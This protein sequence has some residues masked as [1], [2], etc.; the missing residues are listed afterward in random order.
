MIF[1]TPKDR[2]L[3]LSGIILFTFLYFHQVLLR[4]VLLIGLLEHSRHS[5]GYE[6]KYS[7]RKNSDPD[8]F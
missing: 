2:R 1:S 3:K 6:R 7:K 8:V 5:A 4:F